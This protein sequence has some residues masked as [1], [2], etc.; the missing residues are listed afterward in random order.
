MI[1][2]LMDWL[3]FAHHCQLI[4]IGSEVLDS[5][6]IMKYFGVVIRLLDVFLL[7][8]EFRGMMLS[9][10]TQGFRIIIMYLV[11]SFNID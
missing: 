5:S 8:S 3:I 2:A 9:N 1:G 7:L 10:Y 4:F 11:C 6:S